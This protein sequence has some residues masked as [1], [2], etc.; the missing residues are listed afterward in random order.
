MTYKIYLTLTD[1]YDRQLNPK[2]QSDEGFKIFLS[3]FASA[4]GHLQ[5]VPLF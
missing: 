2:V 4:N 5:I 3:K 1:R